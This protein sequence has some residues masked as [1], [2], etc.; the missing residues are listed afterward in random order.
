MSVAELMDG[1]SRLKPDERLA[2]MAYLKH[3]ARKAF[4]ITFWRDEYVRE[5]RVLKIELIDAI[6][7]RP[8]RSYSQVMLAEATT[9]SCQWIRTGQEFFGAMLA[10]IDSAEH[11]V[12]LETYIYNPGKLGERFRTALLRARERGAQVRVLLDAFG[13]YNLPANFWNPLREAGGEVQFFNPLSLSRWGIRNHRKL[14]VCDEQRAF[15]GGFNIS[16]EYEG[17]GVTCGWCDLGMQVCGPLVSEL[18]ESFEEMFERADYQHRRFVRL[19]RRRANR[20]IGAAQG[21]LLLSGPGHGRSPIKTALHR[22]LENA[23]SV[24]MMIAYFLPSWRIRRQLARIVRGGGRVELILAGKSDVSLSRFAGQS[25]YRRLLKGGIEIYEYQPQI[26]HA[27]LMI[28]DSVVY[29]GSA[30]LDQRSL[31]I[32]YELML[33]VQE[34]TVTAAGREIFAKALRHSRRI[35]LTEWRQSRS[36]WNRLKQRWAYLLLVRLDPYIA[37]WQWRGLPD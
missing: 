7:I 21:Q 8:P 26:L 2:L 34:E 33:R 27:K 5:L 14:L 37:R 30:N 15:I 18:S 9:G 23:R 13:S 31:N 4:L 12:R 28:I 32:N 3:L 11:S 36:F 22:D 29:A 10:A 6:A 35:T 16:G 19:G 25:L 17:D 1:A 24:Q 20:V